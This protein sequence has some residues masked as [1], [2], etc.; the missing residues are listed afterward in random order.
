MLVFGYRVVEH[1]DD[2]APEPFGGY[3][4]SPDVKAGDEIQL[5]WLDGRDAY[6]VKVVERDDMTLHVR[7][8]PR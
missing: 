6:M 4:G 8:V 2:E 3:F 5:K 1:Y 7:A